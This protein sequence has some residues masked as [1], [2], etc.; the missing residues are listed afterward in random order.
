[1]R[2]SLL[3]SCA[4]HGVIVLIA[5]AM[6]PRRAAHEPAGAAEIAL[7][8]APPQPIPAVAI[9]VDV[10]AQAGGG[11]PAHPTQPAV[12]ASARPHR[13]SASVATRAVP[14]ETPPAPGP[15]PA[16]AAPPAT[17]DGV[18][19]VAQAAPASGPSR[20][21][22]PMKRRAPATARPRATA[23]PTASA[24]AS[25]PGGRGHGVE[26]RAARALAGQR[27]GGR[28]RARVTRRRISH[29]E[30]TALRTRDRFPRLP[31]SVWPDRRPDVGEARDFGVGADGRG[32]EAA[33][34]L[35]ASA[36]LDP[37]VLAAA[38][39]WQYRPRLVDGKPAPF[40]HG[41]VIKYERW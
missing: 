31:E 41:V 22:P 2:R 11:G 39:T 19:E 30:A 23:S 36:R 1:M 6:M 34:C 28:A 8:A 7:Q 3:F 5:L 18:V 15:T 27:D 35:S 33:P 25:D 37:G 14:A 10:L 26:P 32:H 21:R 24:T 16:L 17:D 38:K 13:R 20:A 9:D 29:D 12:V 40:C 4:L